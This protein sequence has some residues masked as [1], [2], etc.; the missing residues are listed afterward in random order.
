M[1]R[2]LHKEV[3]HERWLKEKKPHQGVVKV[4]KVTAESHGFNGFIGLCVGHK[5]LVRDVLESSAIT[6]SELP[7][8]LKKLDLETF[9]RDR[10]STNNTIAAV[11]DEWEKLKNKE[12]VVV[13]LGSSPSVDSPLTEVRF[14][15]CG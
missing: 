3:L 8:D 15:T 2:K 1:G 13:S 7:L 14:H 5:D 6:K 4:I 12:N 11:M 10:M 9:I